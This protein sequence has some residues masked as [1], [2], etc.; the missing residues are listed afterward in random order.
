MPPTSAI[1]VI[2]FTSCPET[3]ATSPTPTPRRSRTASKTASPE[4]AATRPLISA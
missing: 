2:T 1:S 4:T 3:R